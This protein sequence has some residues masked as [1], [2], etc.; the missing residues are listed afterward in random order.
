MKAATKDKDTIELERLQ[1]LKNS[2]DNHSKRQ[3]DKQGINDK[4]EAT[5]KR[6]QR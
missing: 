3:D 4:I 5:L 1:K 2:T 6:I